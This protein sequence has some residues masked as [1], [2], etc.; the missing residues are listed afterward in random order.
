MLKGVD[1][2]LRMSFD[3]EKQQAIEPLAI[4]STDMRFVFYPIVAWYCK[5]HQSQ[6]LDLNAA[7]LITAAFLNL[8]GNS[9]R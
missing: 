5:F 1:S 2:A 9:T 7:N 6:G 3:G 8:P 4:I